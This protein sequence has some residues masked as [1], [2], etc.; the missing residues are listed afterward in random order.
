MIM[1]GMGVLIEELRIAFGLFVQIT[2]STMPHNS[3]K[4]QTRGTVALG[5]MGNATGDQVLLSLDTR[6]LLRWSHV[7]V[8]KMTSEV[9]A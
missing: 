9:I 6:K 3:L 7:K 5:S 1:T 8:A 4:P 2:S